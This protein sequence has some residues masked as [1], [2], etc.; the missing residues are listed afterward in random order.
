M[1]SRSRF[2]SAKAF[3]ALLADLR[4]RPNIF[5]NGFLEFLEA[6]RLVT[7]VAR[8]TWPTAMVIAAREG[9]PP[10][11]PTKQERQDTE[12]LDAALR[13][14]ERYDADPELPHPFDLGTEMPGAALVHLSVGETEFRPWEAFAVE[15]LQDDGRSFRV[16]DGVDTYYHDWQAL[17]VADAV[18]MGMKV[19][20][21][22]RR[23]ELVEAFEEGGLANMPAG[24][25][26][27]EMSLQNPH[28]LVAGVQWSACLDAAAKVEVIRARVSS[29]ISLRH[30]G[31]PTVFTS[32]E[33]IELNGAAEQAAKAALAAIPAER[34]DVGR[35]LAYLCER[36]DEWSRRGRAEIAAEYKRHIARAA[37]LAMHGF[38]TDFEA[39]SRDLGRV[40]GHFGNT[41]DVIFPDWRREA[42]ET[43]ERS[44]KAVIVKRA[45]TVSS[46]L[47]LEDDD[48]A[49]LLD[50]LERRDQWKIHL[51]MEAMLAR[52]F[53]GVATDRLA[54]AKEVES[55]STTFEHLVSAMSAEAGLPT[56]GTLMPKV[57]AFWAG[58][59]D[60]HTVTKANTGLVNT[61]NG[62][63]AELLAQIAAIPDSGPNT[64]I[65]RTLLTAVLNRNAAQHKD[66]L[67]ALDEADLHATARG[68]FTAMM[69]CRKHLLTLPP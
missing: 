4:L 29:A 46:H 61:K 22:T 62:S 26:Y 58:V 39:M 21:D 55:L 68:F 3:G 43:A 33:M 47:S 64:A 30:H 27:T 13:R 59:S 38:D 49:D 54:L 51:S 32:D 11:P 25:A 5:Q 53:T 16:D 67:S 35:F 50:W 42:R 48:A 63:R 31:E 17:L 34:A 2:M 28:G 66:G 52:Q 18:E 19:I 9:V 14:W 12:D 37:R 36:W 40:A 23:P 6:Q 7:P 24:S 65:A 44:L 69:F 8:V 57:I 41:L 45:P 60:V 20:F 1:A 15:V 56:D 10:T